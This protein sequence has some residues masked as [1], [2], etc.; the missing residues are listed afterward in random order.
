MKNTSLIISVIALIAAVVFGVI[1]LTS[2]KTTA[3]SA[4]TEEAKPETCSA[5][6][7]RPRCTMTV[8]CYYLPAQRVH[9]LIHCMFI[10][11]LLR[12]RHS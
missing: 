9:P 11:C 1:S 5:K 3:D 12:A 4:A 8:F 6:S 10:A 7:P 2:N